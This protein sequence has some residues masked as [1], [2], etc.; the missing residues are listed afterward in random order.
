[1]GGGG[2]QVQVIIGN[3][4][5]ENFKVLEEKKLRLFMFTMTLGMYE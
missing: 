5:K 4:A 1:M 3:T 2:V